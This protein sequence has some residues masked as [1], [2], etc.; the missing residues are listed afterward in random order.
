MILSSPNVECRWHHTM[1]YARVS[2]RWSLMPSRLPWTAS[3]VSLMCWDWLANHRQSCLTGVLLSTRLSRTASL[4]FYSIPP[5]EPK[6][7][8][9]GVILTVRSLLL[10]RWSSVAPLRYSSWS[11]TALSGFPSAPGYVSG[12]TCISSATHLRWWFLLDG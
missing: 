11:R 5:L 12:Q 7:Y 10:Y 2:N 3:S 6:S 9:A 4:R 1:A 8:V